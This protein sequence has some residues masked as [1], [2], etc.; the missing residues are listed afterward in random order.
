MNQQNLTLYLEINHSEYVFFV[1]ENV[2]QNDSNILYKCNIP[3][4][5]IEN[6]RISDF[7][8]IY[9]VIKENIY[10]I[11]KKF[12]YTFKEIILIL[13]NF[14]PTF[15]NLSGY[16]KLNGSQISKENITYVL[17][18][19]KSC[20]DEIETK[21]TVLHIFNTKYNLDNKKIEN[22]PIGLFGDFYS[23][24]LSFTLIN[25]NDYK[26]IKNIFDQINL[27][28]KKILLQ[29]YVKGAFINEKNK[30]VDTF[31]LVKINNYNSKI[32]YFENSS[33]KY[34]QDFKFGYDIIIKD[35]SKITHLKKRNIEKILNNIEFGKKISADEV[36]EKEFF[37]DE[38][39]RKIK[40]KLLLDIISAR[41][42]EIF[43]LLISKNINCTYNINSPKR[44]FLE[45]DY[46]QPCNCLKE[47]YKSIFS[48]SQNLEVI[49]LEIFS[50]DD[51][52]KMVNK[53]V[54][55]GWKKEAIP[56]TQVKKTLI[57]KFFDA[58]FG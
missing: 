10:L 18:T 44:L 38:N 40:K 35:I 48:A 3:L 20:V 14:N 32:F 4:S 13:E 41:I 26:N 39:F 42:E 29:S 56:I 25:N 21:R 46:D 51:K 57:A 12:N 22:L 43:E 28:I 45:Q 31:F 36:I 6:N 58:I 52:L 15:I 23:H 2:D 1:G 16:K 24:E 11:E 34:E 33:L 5:G 17:N 30:N 55:F 27:K 7:D 8:K 54:H 19:L 37:L 49:P 9:G 47:A 50:D 53:L